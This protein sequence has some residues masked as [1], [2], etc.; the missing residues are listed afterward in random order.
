MGK[1]PPKGAQEELQRLKSNFQVLYLQVSNEIL[2]KNWT[3]KQKKVNALRCAPAKLRTLKSQHMFS[4]YLK[5]AD[6]YRQ[7]LLW[8]IILVFYL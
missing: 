8:S 5:T 4:L 1:S 6:Y 3:E 2:I 7:A